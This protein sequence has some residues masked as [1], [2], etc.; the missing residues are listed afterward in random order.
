M[1][2]IQTRICGRDNICRNRSETRC[3][4]TMIF[5]AINLELTNGGAK[6]TKVRSMMRMSTNLNYILTLF[7]VVYFVADI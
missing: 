3:K 5:S 2:A 6:P 4:Y 7:L 1:Q